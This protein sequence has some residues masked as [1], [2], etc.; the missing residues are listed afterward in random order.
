MGYSRADLELEDHVYSVHHWP[1]M[2]YLNYRKARA[3]H[4]A[5]HLW[6]VPPPAPPWD[7]FY[8]LQPPQPPTVW[9]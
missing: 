2:P 1:S 5:E 7:L 4:L 6:G 3:Q 8:S 9:D